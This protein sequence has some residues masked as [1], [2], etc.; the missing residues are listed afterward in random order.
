MK[1]RV[2]HE[3]PLC[4]LEESRVYN[5]YDYA[6]VHLFEQEP[7]YY[8]FFKASVTMNRE[9]LL[10]NSI[11]ELG[12]AFDSKAYVDWICNLNPTYYIVPDVLENHQETVD[13]FMDFTDAYSGVPGLRI[14]AVQGKTYQELVDCY[15]FMADCADYIAMSFDF[16]YYQTT[17][18]GN[19]PLERMMTGRQRL[20]ADLID[21]GIWCWDKPMHLLGCSL[22]QE[23]KYYTNNNIYNIRSV[24]TSNPIMAGIK[25]LKYAGNLGLTSKPQGLLA[26][27]L[28][29]Q[30]D[31]DQQSLIN[32]NIKSFRSIID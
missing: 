2:S 5:D 15:K 31:P 7:A 6:L 11:F 26:N 32:Y 14:G 16:S 27:H 20:I 13:S 23:F 9:V 17:G 18:R 10:D 28:N 25:R 19:T 4:L 1:V 22:P 3:S 29:V 21:D 12:K 30:L 8:A 24:D